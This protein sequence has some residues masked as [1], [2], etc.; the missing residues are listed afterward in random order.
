[1]VAKK[2]SDILGVIRKTVA[3]KLREVMLPLYSA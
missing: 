1:M 2:A 3:N